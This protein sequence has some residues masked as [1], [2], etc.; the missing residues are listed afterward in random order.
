M[1]DPEAEMTYLHSHT[2]HLAHLTDKM[3]QG[4]S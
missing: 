3:D 4:L 1:V 2:E